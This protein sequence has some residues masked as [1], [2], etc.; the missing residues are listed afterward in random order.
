MFQV[1]NLL[2]WAVIF[3]IVAI[4]GALLGFGGIAGTAMA[5]AKLLFW[6][7]IIFAIIALVFGMIRRP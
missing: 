6:V 3:L 5:G 2:H 1:G 7:A 4:V